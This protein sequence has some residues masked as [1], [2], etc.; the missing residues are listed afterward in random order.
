MQ[1]IIAEKDQEIERLKKH[2]SF[3]ESSPDEL[4]QICKDAERNRIDAER[5]RKLRRMLAPSNPGQF[6][7]TTDDAEEFSVRTEYYDP[8][9]ISRS[10]WAKFLYHP[11]IEAANK[12]A[13]RYGKLKAI[14]DD[15]SFRHWQIIVPYAPNL[16]FDAAVDALPEVKK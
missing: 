9:Y 2:L 8:D 11:L 13:E 4:D 10:E 1:Q 15:E 7:K 3:Y 14:A 12:D 5:Y 6:D 16:Q